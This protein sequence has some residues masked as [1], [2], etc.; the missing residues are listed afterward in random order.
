MMRRVDILPESYA[1]RRQEQRQV[2]FVII[3]GLL[4]V[5][6]LFGW[7]FY[8][9]TQ[10][11]DAESRLSDIQAD[12]ARIQAEI[13]KLQRFAD[14]DAAITSKTLALD[15]VM[16][17]DVNWPAVLTEIA[18]V[19]PGE[20]WLTDLTGS[21][22]AVEGSAPAG[23]ETAPI[24]PTTNQPFGRI[25]FTGRSLNMPGVA[26][27]MI[28]L[29]TVKKFATAWLND[30]VELDE[31]FAGGVRPIE[32]ENTIELSDKAASQGRFEEGT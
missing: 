1:R 18:L 7:W 26:K 12:N 17:G 5:L 11:S 6:L 2:G 28:R 21:A 19:I 32:F 30:A 20:V 15:T 10:I 14:L 3:A 22:G 13:D 24:R 16:A 27:W 9:G 4:V 8:L 29:Q 31:E 23:T 25:V